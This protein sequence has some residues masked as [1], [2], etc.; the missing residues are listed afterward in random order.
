MLMQWWK[1]TTGNHLDVGGVRDNSKGVHT[2]TQ[3]NRQLPQGDGGGGNL[4]FWCQVFA[5]QFYDSTSQQQQGA[6]AF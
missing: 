4:R 3:T 2:F 5:I 1:T 6:A